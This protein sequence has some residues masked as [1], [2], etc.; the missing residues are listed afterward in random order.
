MSSTQSSR[1]IFREVARRSGSAREVVCKPLRPNIYVR[2]KKSL[3]ALIRTEE[4]LSGI[5]EA[6]RIIGGVE[7]AVRDLAEGYVL[8]KPNCNSHDPFPASTHPDTL[9]FVVRQL[10]DVGLERE[11]IV[12]GDMSGPAW[13]PTEDTMRRN[14]IL[15]AVEELDV[16]VSFFED[17]EWVRVKPR[18]AS[19]WPEGFRIARKS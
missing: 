10:L 4:R 12:V 18:D 14:G 7:P 9:R 8:V 2:N 15:S 11:K 1:E 16:N 3:V 17:E 13:L 6:I 19:S 5:A